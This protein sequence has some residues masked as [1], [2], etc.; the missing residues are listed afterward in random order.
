[1]MLAA[2]NAAQA[3]EESRPVKEEPIEVIAEKVDNSIK[4]I[5]GEDLQFSLS[6][7]LNDIFKKNPA[8]AVGGGGMPLAQKVYV[9]GFEDTRLNVSIDGATQAGQA[10]HHQSRVYIDPELLKAV[11]VEAGAGAATNGPG[12][13]VGAIRY[14]TKSASD[15]LREG[16]DFG[17]IAKTGYYSNSEGWKGS[18][19]L[20]GKVTEDLEVL[21]TLSRAETGDWED[22][23]GKEW[24]HSDTNQQV[25][26]FKLDYRLNEANRMSLSYENSSDEALRWNRANFGFEF[27]HPVQP[28]SLNQQETVR[29]TVIF[30]HY[31]NPEENDLVDMRFTAFYTENEMERDDFESTYGGGGV[32]SYGF[33]L[34][35][36][37]IIGDHGI[38]YGADYRYDEAYSIDAV[39]PWTYD[40]DGDENASVFGLYAQDNWRFH[41]DWLLSFG[42][43]YD[44]YDHEDVDGEEHSMDGFSPNIGLT[45]FVNDALSVYANASR[46]VRGM[47]VEESYFVFYKD[48]IEPGIKEEIAENYEIG[49]T[50]DDNSLFFGLELFHQE[51]NDVLDYGPRGAPYEIMNIGD[52]EADG[53]SAHAGYRFDNLTFT[54][55]VSQSEP[56]LNGEPVTDGTG[57]ANSSGRTWVADL[58]YEVPQANLR[59]GWLSRFVEELDHVPSGYD[60]KSSYDVYDLYVQWQPTGEDDWTVNFAVS[61]LFDRHYYDHTTLYPGGDG[62]QPDK[63]RDFRIELSYKF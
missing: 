58:N 47:G 51:I 35:N 15:L 43:R 21:T 60:N 36:T 61:N 50:Y 52:L 34:R 19:T 53:F 16:Q 3:Q 29:E 44:W 13:L 40:A 38:T 26:F 10:Y 32:E 9:R 48:S 1:M 14:E 30:N 55:S 46:V 33:D 12:A 7:S 45:Y 63:G 17:A 11:Q 27:T 22:G 59:L 5:D 25:G 39:A 54:L 62:G 6:S 23:D 8:V 49:F 18:L 56:E 37:S 41:D 57:I 28:N 31:F 4:T 2:A 20:Y 24:S 42:A